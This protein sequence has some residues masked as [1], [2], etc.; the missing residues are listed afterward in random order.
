MSLGRERLQPTLGPSFQVYATR[1]HSPGVL[2]V[3]PTLKIA[4]KGFEVRK[5]QQ[6]KKKERK[7]DKRKETEQSSFHCQH[8]M[9]RGHQRCG[10]GLPLAIWDLSQ[11]AAGWLSPCPLPATAHCQTQPSSGAWVNFAVFLLQLLLKS[12][13]MVRGQWD[14]MKRCPKRS[15]CP[16]HGMLYHIFR[17]ALQFQYI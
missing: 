11:P 10:P 1:Q 12:W 9:A 8:R 3:C 13:R 14:M 17:I 5:K 4:Q 2:L 15:C 16:D 6:E 7:K